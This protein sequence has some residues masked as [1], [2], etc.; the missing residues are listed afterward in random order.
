LAIQ[1]QGRHL[2]LSPYKLP[3]NSYSETCYCPTIDLPQWLEQA[4]C[5]LA[6]EQ[7]TADLIPFRSINFT[8]IRSKIVEKFND[9]GSVS[10]CNYVIKNNEIWR[11]CYGK[12]TGFKMFMD[13]IL[14]S[15]TKKMRFD[16]KFKTKRVPN[17]Q[18]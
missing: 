18:Q 15:M 16:G 17:H 4:H 10:I 3:G 9:P 2:G 6:E 12:Y 11:K 14:L 1:L 13:A 7:I 8:A 5:R